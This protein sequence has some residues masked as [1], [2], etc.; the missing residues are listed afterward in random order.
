[1]EISLPLTAVLS[2]SLSSWL[3]ANWL[4]LLVPQQRQTP[5]GSLDF[6]LFLDRLDNHA[7]SL[8]AYTPFCLARRGS[9]LGFLKSYL[10]SNISSS[11]LFN[12]FFPLRF[13]FLSLF[14]KPLLHFVV[15]E[16]PSLASRLVVESE[17]GNGRVF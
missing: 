3:R 7:R 16:N 15:S 12:F 8:L 6:F 9:S 13:C 11:S 14:F 10:S 2:L 1:M 4:L 17:G 5:T